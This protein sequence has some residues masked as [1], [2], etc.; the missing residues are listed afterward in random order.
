MCSLDHLKAIKLIDVELGCF[1]T[2]LSCLPNLQG[3]VLFNCQIP[4]KQFNL[5]C[6]KSIRYIDISFNPIEIKTVKALM[7]SYPNIEFQFSKLP[8]DF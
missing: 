1:P 6:F 5:G 7:N 3:L 4:D 2:E 8:S